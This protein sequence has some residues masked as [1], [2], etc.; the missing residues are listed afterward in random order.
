MTATI[1]VACSFVTTV[2]PWNFISFR[3]E[4]FIHK[5]SLPKACALMYGKIL[6]ISIQMKLNPF[7][8]YSMIQE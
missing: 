5:L 2:S 7:G 6:V 8:F 3:N 1:A 4:A